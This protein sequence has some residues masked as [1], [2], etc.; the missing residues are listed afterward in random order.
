MYHTIRRHQRLTRNDV[1]KELEEL[2]KKY[3][4]SPSAVG[5]ATVSPRCDAE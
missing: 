2:K 5:P 1:M 4:R 3:R